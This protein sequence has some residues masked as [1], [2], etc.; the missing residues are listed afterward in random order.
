MNNVNIGNSGEYFVAGELERRGFSVAVPMSNT[1]E[2]DI[3][4]INMKNKKQYAVQLKTKTKN[5]RKLILKK[6]NEHLIGDNIIYVFVYLN[7]LSVPKYYIVPSKIVAETIIINHQV[8]L[9]ALGRNGKPH[10]D[11]NM[12]KFEIYDDKFL[13]NWDLFK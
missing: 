8:W 3:L 11:S 2:F 13:N 4:T 1:K 12:R 10:K 6:E 5:K 9:N 7:N